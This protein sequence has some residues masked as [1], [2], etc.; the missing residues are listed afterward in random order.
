MI[1]AICAALLGV[2]IFITVLHTSLDNRYNP[3]KDNG[4]CPTGECMQGFEFQDTCEYRPNKEGVH[5]DSQCL[6]GGRG[7]CDGRGG[8]VGQC[9]GNCNYNISAPTQPLQTVLGTETESFCGPY[10]GVQHHMW[11]P[12]L[13]PPFFPCS[14][15]S[16]ETAEQYCRS[17]LVGESK[18]CMKVEAIC[19]E[20]AIAFCY[21][22]YECATWRPH[23]EMTEWL[24][25]DDGPVIAARSLKGQDGVHWRNVKEK[26]VTLQAELQA[27]IDGQDS[28]N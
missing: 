14:G 25:D 10:Y 23:P 9:K 11:L 13:G 2:G 27:F 1:A 4:D 22:T 26:F 18:E 28:T 20:G 5:C 17:A 12:L 7:H 8:C 3:R 21:G 24:E 15:T 6:V 16:D 19:E